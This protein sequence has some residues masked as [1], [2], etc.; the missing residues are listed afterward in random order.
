MSFTAIAKRP[1]VRD[2]GDVMKRMDYAELEGTKVALVLVTLRIST[3]QISRLSNQQ[4]QISLHIYIPLPSLA[5]SRS[6]T[7]S[8]M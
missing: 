4:T 1:A 3:I 7:P 8:K 2:T 5:S 6:S